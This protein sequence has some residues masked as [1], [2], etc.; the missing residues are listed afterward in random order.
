MRFRRFT[1]F[2]VEPIN[3]PT[4]NGGICV[5][6]DNFF[7]KYWRPF[8]CWQYGIVCFL[9]VGVLPI[10]SWLFQVNPALGYVLV[11]SPGAATY[12]M[13]MGAIAG[14]SAWTRTVE[15]QTAMRDGIPP[16]PINTPSEPFR[17][18]PP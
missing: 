4:G 16:P 11:N 1:T 15:K 3:Q 12:H 17:K 8:M 7:T 6:H 18:T 5:F 9:D 2:K 14:V 13:A 10:I